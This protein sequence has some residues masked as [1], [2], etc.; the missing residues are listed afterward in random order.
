MVS[1][2]IR[3]VYSEMFA[4]EKKVADFVLDNANEVLEMNIAEMAE[5]SG[6]SD[7]TIIRMC[8][9]IG[10]S[11]F[12]QM[13]INLAMELSAEQPEQTDVND[14]AVSFFNQISLSIQNIA[15]NIDMEILHKCVD[16]ISGAGCVYLTG[17][18]NTGT[19]AADLAH[20][21]SR[22]GVLTFVTDVS[23][24]LIR[25]LNLGKENDIMIAVSHSG[26]SLHVIQAIE[27]AKKRG[28]KTILITNA[29]SSK[30]ADASD[31]V[32]RSGIKEQIRQG[33]GGE[34][35]I[36]EMAI[37]DL[38]LF[39]LQKKSPLKDNVEITEEILSQYK[40]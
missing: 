8:K 7:A 17:W 13:K 2:N 10:F 30:A 16:A 1:D 33:F 29:L 27:L 24:Y 14:D 40:I 12:Y 37:I 22:R 35:H 19:V 21:L 18:G 11:G 9:R 5:Q 36:Y 38:L 28:M 31:Y 6:T 23:E 3:R 34:S 32:L 20:R 4:A 15:K 39:F 26:T 25:N